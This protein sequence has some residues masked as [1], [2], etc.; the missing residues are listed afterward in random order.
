[1][2]K[3]FTFVLLLIGVAA[4]VHKTYGPEDVAAY[5]KTMKDP[6]WAARVIY[7]SA[8]VL[9][10]DERWKEAVV[11]FEYLLEKFPENEYKWP[12]TF[13]LAASY[14]GTSDWKKAKE[15]YEAY[16]AGAPD[17][18]LAPLAREKVEIFKKW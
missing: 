5:A 13:Y 17:G 3:L 2:M 9:H 11:E 8:R 15:L 1:M 7:Y 4:Y 18:E 6:K 14:E 12:A 10:N 16:L